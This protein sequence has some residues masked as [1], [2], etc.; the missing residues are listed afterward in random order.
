MM[1]WD[2]F[3]LCRI[4]KKTLN[5]LAILCLGKTHPHKRD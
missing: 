3:A 1:F 2:D 5:P 4:G